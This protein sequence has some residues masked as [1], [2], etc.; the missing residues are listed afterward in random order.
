MVKKYVLLIVFWTASVV[1]MVTPC[2]KHVHQPLQCLKVLFSLL[3]KKTIGELR[4][5]IDVCN[6]Q[7]KKKKSA[8][9]LVYELLTTGCLWR[10]YFTGTAW[11][12]SRLTLYFPAI[13]S[14]C[15]QFLRLL[16]QQRT[17][18]SGSHRRNAKLCRLALCLRCQQDCLALKSMLS[19]ISFPEF[20]LPCCLNAPATFFNQRFVR[21]HPRSN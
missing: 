19:A 4:D 20:S 1:F 9:E 21:G 15:L 5:K 18:P 12:S 14:K 2:L 7:Q 16:L 17:G 3:K 6:L 13:F 10:T 11:F 8:F